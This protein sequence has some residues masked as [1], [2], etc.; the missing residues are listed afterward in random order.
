MKRKIRIKKLPKAQ[1]G[2]MVPDYTGTT[3]STPSLTSG[4]TPFAI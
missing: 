3:S 2:I 4:M 1:K